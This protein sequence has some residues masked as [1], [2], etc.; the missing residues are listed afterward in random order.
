MWE[1]LLILTNAA[2]GDVTNIIIR[3]LDVVTLYVLRA[4]RNL[5]IADVKTKTNVAVL[6]DRISWDRLI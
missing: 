2:I 3:A 5:K 6:I 4:Y 1:I